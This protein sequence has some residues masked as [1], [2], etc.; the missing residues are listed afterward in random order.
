M[1][2]GGTSTGNRPIQRG[3]MSSFN[4]TPIERRADAAAA[5]REM[6][7]KMQAAPGPDDPAVLARR[8]ERKAIAEA[9]AAREA[10]KAAAAEQ[11]RIEQAA[12]EAAEAVERELAAAR[13]DEERMAQAAALEEQKQR[14]RDERYAARKAA[15]R[16]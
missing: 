5:K 6:I 7:R 8:A 4:K 11:A 2:L 10:A 12:R 15:K 9:R 1:R 14:A 16:R 3:E 13:A